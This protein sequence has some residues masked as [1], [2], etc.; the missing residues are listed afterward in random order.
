[1]GI[2]HL[3]SPNGGQTS[4]RVSDL[5]ESAI[6]LK[7]VQ[8][9]HGEGGYGRRIED[10]FSVGMPDLVLIPKGGP[11]V[12]VEVKIIRGNILTPTP[13]QLVEMR[14]L[15]R[16]P[17]STSYQIGW[18]DGHLYLSPPNMDVPLEDCLRMRD[19]EFLGDFIRRA[20]AKEDG[21]AREPQPSETNTK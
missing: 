5:K 1:M 7:M 9:I 21:N 14:R 8:E 16:P 10:R 13:R 18:K 3:L 4:K 2:E 19:N 20:I 17:H 15:H 11:V 6:K 12:W